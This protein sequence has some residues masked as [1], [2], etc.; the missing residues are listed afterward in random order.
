MYYV[1]IEG[2]KAL[3]VA[4]S[5][6]PLVRW[7]LKY[8]NQRKKMYVEYINNIEIECDGYILAQKHD[9]IGT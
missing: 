3:W 2:M 5:H 4:N 6:H 8:E 1:E 7:K 9:Y